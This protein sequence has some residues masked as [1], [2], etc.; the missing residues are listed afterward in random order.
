MFK[1]MGF[2]RIRVYMRKIITIIMG[3][4]KNKTPIRVAIMFFEMHVC[5]IRHSFLTTLQLFN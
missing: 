2:I 5:S 4:S 3:I 1:M